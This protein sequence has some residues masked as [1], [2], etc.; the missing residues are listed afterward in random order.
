LIGWS[1][2][3]QPLRCRSRLNLNL[4]DLLSRVHSLSAF[5]WAEV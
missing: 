3:Q 5:K 4:I 2:D 1:R